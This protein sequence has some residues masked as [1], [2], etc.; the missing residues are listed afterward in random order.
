MQTQ[1]DLRDVPS[2]KEIRGLEDLLVRHAVLA[3]ASLE[4]DQINSFN[5]DL[6]TRMDSLTS[7]CSP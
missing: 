2:L 3:N 6:L 4:P 1:S 7:E 5:Y